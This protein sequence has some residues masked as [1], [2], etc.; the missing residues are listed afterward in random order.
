[1]HCTCTVYLRLCTLHFIFLMV[2]ESLR[3]CLMMTHHSGECGLLKNVIL[4]ETERSDRM[5]H[6]L[7]MTYMHSKLVKD[8]NVPLS[9]WI[10][11]SSE[12]SSCRICFQKSSKMHF[13][14]LRFD[15]DAFL[16]FTALS[17]SIIT[18]IRY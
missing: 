6:F 8:I 5:W 4:V 16:T 13:G 3:L 10:S 15:I 17:V 1:M 2:I 11:E 18:I 9:L 14:M 12:N 7:Y